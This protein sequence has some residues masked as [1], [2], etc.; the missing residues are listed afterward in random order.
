MPEKNREYDMTAEDLTIDGMGVGRIDGMAVFAEG[1]LPGE[2]GRVL[3][4]KKAKKYY[5][6]IRR[7]CQILKGL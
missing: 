2:R 5:N 1:L 6:K 3:V 7:K 4:I